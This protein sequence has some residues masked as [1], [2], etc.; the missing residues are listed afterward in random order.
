MYDFGD[1]PERR[2]CHH[3]NFF[4]ERHKRI[5]GHCGITIAIA[6]VEIHIA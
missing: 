1:T 2:L 5:A 6:I 3:H 4:V